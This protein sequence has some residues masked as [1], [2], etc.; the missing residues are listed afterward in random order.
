MAQL[1][2]LHILQSIRRIIRAIDI[3]TKKLKSEYDM[4]AV[5][6]LCLQ[7]IHSSE[8]VTLA[9]LSNLVH[10]SASTLVG[11]VDRLEAKGL[12]KRERSQ[13]DRRYTFIVLT[14]EGLEKLDTLPPALH[15]KL[16]DGLEKM[17]TETQKLLVTA[18]NHI[19]RL[20]EADDVD[21]AP[22][23]ETGK[24]T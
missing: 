13:K 7:M 8:A 11:V 6:I 16:S 19:V 20:I 12:I 23:L 1:T 24:L 2:Q 9:G 4:T 10:V 3:Y 17:D 5:Q 15:D 14:D 18:L 22:V 21:A